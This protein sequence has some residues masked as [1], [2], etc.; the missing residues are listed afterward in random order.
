[1][2]RYGIAS[3]AVGALVL[4]VC[5]EQGN[6]ETFQDVSADHWA[7]SEIEYIQEQE[8]IT[9][10]SD[11]TFRPEEFISRGQAAT[12]L[13]RSLELEVETASG[14]NY[15]DVP[16]K[17][18]YFSEINAVSEAEIMNGSMEE[19]RPEAPLTRAQL[20]AILQRAFDLEASQDI[21]FHDVNTSHWAYEHIAAVVS[22]RIATGR[23]D[24][25]YYPNEEVSREYLAVFMSRAL[26]E[27]F[28]PD[29][30]YEGDD[31]DEQPW[32]FRGFELGD[33]LKDIEEDL[34][35]PEETMPSRYGFQWHIYHD[36]YERYIQYG[37]SD[38][39]TIVGAITPQD[40]WQGNGGIDN[41]ATRSDVQEEYGEP[42]SSMS[43]GDVNYS[44]EGKQ[45]DAYLIDNMYITFYYDGQN[46][47]EVSN[48]MVIDAD[49][50]DAFDQ[51]FAE[52]TSEMRASYKSQ[53]HHISNAVR[54]DRGKGSTTPDD[55]ALGTARK[56]SQDMA[57]SQYFDH[58]NLDGDG[59]FDRMEAEGIAFHSAAE[60]LA[61]GYPS[62]VDA[63][64]GWLNSTNGHREALLGNYDYSAVGV[65]F[66]ER[67]HR[68]YYTQLLYTKP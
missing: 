43:K 1:M 55:D 49:V 27:D 63:V 38:D 9:G 5:Q 29:D 68:P 16:E 37:V 24:G 64:E 7:S 67:N 12:I 31:G 54:T 34:G 61:R 21:D 39:G 56:H 51:Y 48:I 58:V 14:I 10:Y 32:A 30:A 20:S 17:H 3:I 25:W 8:I 36:N 45:K 50:E 2:K 18:P 57:R 62:P 53:V 28:R 22:E 41:H 11:G 44:L 42:L 46:H 4:F 13:A 47:D 6:A 19:F 15:E 23:D 60:N 59:P 35:S 52:P 66:D 33:S 40:V 26:N 65:A